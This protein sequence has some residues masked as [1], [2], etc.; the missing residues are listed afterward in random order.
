[1]STLNLAKPFVKARWEPMV[2]FHFRIAPEILKPFAPPMFELDLYDGT[3]CL[4][5]AVVHMSGFRSGRI[6]SR[7]LI[8]QALRQ[9]RFLNL[10][11]YVKWQGEPGV[12]FLHGWL[13]RPW[14]LP[15]PSRMFG[16]PYRFATFNSHRESG[17]LMGNVKSGEDSFS[18]RAQTPATGSAAICP[19]GSLAEFAMEQY[20]GYFAHRNQAAA[21]HAWHPPWQ[22]TPVKA[23]INDTTLVTNLFPWFAHARFAGAH[24]TE[25][26]DDVWLSRAYRL[27]PRG[28]ARGNHRVLSAFYEMP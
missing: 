6:C 8:V 7:G 9:Q 17:S 26:I 5:L 12:L 20:H 11:I 1:M 21:F 27:P 15:L 19:S 16:L 23:E 3:A 18:Y 4:S 25:P 2:F 22:Q 28:P 14:K 24:L 13:S 10:R